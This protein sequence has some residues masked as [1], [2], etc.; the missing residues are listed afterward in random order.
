MLKKALLF[1]GMLASLAACGRPGAAPG[2]PEKAGID[3]QGK[4]LR[5]GEASAVAG[6]PLLTLK[7]GAIEGDPYSSYSGGDNR[8][9]MILD[10]RNASSR[11]ILQ[12]NDRHIAQW[13]VLGDDEASSSAD[14]Y[15]PVRTDGNSLSTHYV[16]VVEARA[17]RGEER[18]RTYDVLLG[19]FA[20][21]RQVWIAKGVDG[22]IHARKLQAG[23]ILLI[24]A[25][26]GRTFV[27][28]FAPDSLVLQRTT[29]L[30]V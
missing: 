4:P 26:R 25:E 11:K 5:L 9:V 3:T 7:I 21:G 20:D 28:Y 30:K 22:L 23:S 10:P 14:R 6:T 29:E 24:M 15:A 8:N 2:A 27:R 12:T 16:A 19:S 17:E 18:H 1:V 13:H